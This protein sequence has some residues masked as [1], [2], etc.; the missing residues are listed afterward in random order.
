MSATENLEELT[1][2][3]D[4]LKIDIKSVLK[5]NESINKL[6]PIFEKYLEDSSIEIEGR[7][8]I[9]DEDKK[10]FSSNIGNKNYQIIENL[11]E[12]C[13]DWT[14]KK[15]IHQTDYSDGKLRLTQNEDGTQRCIKKTR[16]HV[17]DFIIDNG[18]LDFRIAIN[19]EISVDVDTFPV[20]KKSNNVRKKDRKT[21]SYKMWD[22]DLTKVTTKKGK[23]EETS[24]EF[25]IELI[26]QRNE[27]NDSNYLAESLLLKI[28][29]N[30]KVCGDMDNTSIRIVK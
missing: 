20:T 22:F 18:P 17:E 4:N 11:L 7:I 3:F 26:K 14:E 8:G 16:K 29:D 5:L 23:I 1:E 24:Y 28:L 6:K 13:N 10:K 19:E 25:E 2:F 15:V 27:I 21:F 30:I 9:Y 12:S